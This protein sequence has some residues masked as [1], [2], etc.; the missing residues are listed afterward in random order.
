MSIFKMDELWLV[1][2]CWIGWV[3]VLLTIVFES[4]ECNINNWTVIYH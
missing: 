2:Q 4:G 3:D 1:N